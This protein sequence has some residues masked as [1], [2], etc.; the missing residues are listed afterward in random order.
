VAPLTLDDTEGPE[1]GN[2]ASQASSVDSFYNLRYVF[3]GL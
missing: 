3:I 2:L 1:S